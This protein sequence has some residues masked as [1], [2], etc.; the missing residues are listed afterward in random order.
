MV[1]P[2][3][4]VGK[5]G[6]EVIPV[7]PM[8]GLPP[9]WLRQMPRERRAALVMLAAMLLLLLSL[10]IYE[11]WTAASRVRPPAQVGQPNGQGLLPDNPE[12]TGATGAGGQPAEAGAAP[13][14]PT[15][16]QPTPAQPAP[17]SIR[18]PLRGSP[19]VLQ[20]FGYRYSELYADFRLHAGMDLAAQA[21]DPVLAAAAGQV[22]AIEQDPAEGLMLTIDHGGGLQ[23]RYAGLG[24]LL[25]SEGAAVAE[26]QRIAE[27]G[28][29]GPA[30]AT[31]GVHLHF[32]LLH[33]GAPVD[34]ARYLRK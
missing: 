16:A 29:P 1:W 8:R 11:R 33:H 13:V 4:P 22:L 30:R 5:L 2:G 32:G 31:L 25:V 24:R 21:G 3:L 18:M 12:S 26:G 17:I 23:S 19:R 34:P 14:Q 10:L 20:G 27:V 28:E 9:D 15:P 7:K 6:P